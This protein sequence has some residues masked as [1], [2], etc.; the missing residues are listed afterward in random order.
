MHNLNVRLPCKNF[1]GRVI[2]YST[3]NFLQMVPPGALT[4]EFRL[5]KLNKSFCNGQNG[6]FITPVS[7]RVVK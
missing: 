3:W 2:M 1:D 7:G 5:R 4:C 6:F